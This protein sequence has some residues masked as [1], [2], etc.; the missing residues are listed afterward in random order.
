MWPQIIHNDPKIFFTRANFQ[1]MLLG[2][3]GIGFHRG[4]RS[5]EID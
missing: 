4:P 3:I 5:E 1:P 2:V